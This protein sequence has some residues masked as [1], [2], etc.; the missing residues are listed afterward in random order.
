MA[1]LRV[2][3][4]VQR[5]D[6]RLWTVELGFE[7]LSPSQHYLGSNQYHSRDILKKRG[8]GAQAFSLS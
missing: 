2:W 5:Q 6:M 7:S 4:I 8:L 3:G 1:R